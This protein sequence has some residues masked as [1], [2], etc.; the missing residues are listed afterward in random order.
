MY[1]AG[2]RVEA[3]TLWMWLANDHFVEREQLEVQGCGS[4]GKGTG[5][6]RPCS[7]LCADNFWIMSESKAGYFTST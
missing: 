5:V 3:P 6:I 7:I 4:E 2:K 1:P